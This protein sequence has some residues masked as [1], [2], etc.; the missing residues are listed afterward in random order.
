MTKSK[1]KVKDVA[2]EN[3]LLICVLVIL[4]IAIIGLVIS[5]VLRNQLS[6][7]KEE[8]QGDG[9]MSQVEEGVE[10]D[11]ILPGEVVLGDDE[12]ANARITELQEQINGTEDN[13]EK[14]KLFGERIDYIWSTL[15]TDAYREQVISDVIAM[16]ELR[17]TSSSAFQVINVAMMYRD[18]ELEEEYDQKASERLAA[19]GVDLSGES[20]GS[21]R[22]E[23]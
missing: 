12:E 4:V 8:G 19:E 15:G 23:E 13:E 7:T 9:G 10:S 3:A 22:A 14:V 17:Q 21:D 11:E 1:K 18:E 16:D 20:A 6:G 2:K 5:L